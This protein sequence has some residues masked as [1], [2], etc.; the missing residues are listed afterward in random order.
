MS[1]HQVTTGVYRNVFI[2]LVMLTALTLALSF[3][4]PGW[5][6]TPV[7]LLIAAAK[8]V[9]I[10]LFFMHLVEQ[11]YTNRIVLLVCLLLLGTLIVLTVADV[12]T[13]VVPLHA[14]GLQ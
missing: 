2:A 4:P 10:L 5:F 7:A 13:R 12:R 1:D 6:H 11:R 9:L 3:L 8:A 14:P